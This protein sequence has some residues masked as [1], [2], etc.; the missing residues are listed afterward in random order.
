MKKLLYCFIV[1]LVFLL[2]SKIIYCDTKKNIEVNQK[3]QKYEIYNPPVLSLDSRASLSRNDINII[4]KD[5]LNALLKYKKIYHKELNT[6]GLQYN[7]KW[8]EKLKDIANDIKKHKNSIIILESFRN[9]ELSE[10]ENISLSKENALFIASVFRD[11]YNIKYTMVAIG[12]GTDKNEELNYN[13]VIITIIEE[14]M[15][16]DII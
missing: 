12:R 1:V 8:V 15:P 6:I 13:C 2:F 4:K 14:P 3:I 9:T 5:K 7:D 10:K 11:V 16:S